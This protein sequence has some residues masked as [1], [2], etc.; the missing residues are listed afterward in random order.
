M[1]Y[2]HIHAAI[3]LRSP[4]SIQLHNGMF[5]P[6]QTDSR[7]PSL[8]VPMITDVFGVLHYGRLVS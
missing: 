5:Q 4:K 2:L 6:F 3:C 1:L 8:D 7:V